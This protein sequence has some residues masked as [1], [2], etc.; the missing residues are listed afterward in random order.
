MRAS[1]PELDVKDAAARLSRRRESSCGQ[2]TICGQPRRAA[3]RTTW[4]EWREPGES[5]SRA[6]PAA[7]K[8][9]SAAAAD[10]TAS[11]TQDELAANDLALMTA[12]AEVT[13]LAAT[14]QEF[15][16]GV[17]LDTNQAVLRVQQIQN[18]VAALDEKVRQG[19]ITAPADGTLYSLPVKAGDY[20]KLGICWRKWRTCT[21]FA[22]V[23]S[24][25][26]RSSAR[27]KRMSR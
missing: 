2:R 15:D 25:M 6:R 12:R 5:A 14:K 11:A 20:V 24:S 22:C 10:R 7:E 8:S 3:E 18:E 13:R 16:R 23:R 1:D 9:R 27:W 4:R 26:S 19:R 17:G 21:R